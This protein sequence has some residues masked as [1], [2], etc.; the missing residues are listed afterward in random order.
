MLLWAYTNK[1]H[2]QGDDDYTRALRYRWSRFAEEGYSTNL[3]NA[4][5]TMR[6]GVSSSTRIRP[7]TPGNRTMYGSLATGLPAA[8]G[9]RLTYAREHPTMACSAPHSFSLVAAE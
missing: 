9:G 7:V 1:K 3:T 8:C 4:K 2:Y 6:S 5:L